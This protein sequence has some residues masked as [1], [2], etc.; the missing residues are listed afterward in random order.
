VARARLKPI[1][2]WAVLGLIACGWLW[3]YV[4]FGQDWLNANIYLVTGLALNMLMKG[5]FASE[6][7]QQ[8]AQDRQS[9]TLEL[10]LSTPLTVHD[11]LQGERLALQRQFLGPVLVVLATGLVLMI[12]TAR[13]AGV[14]EDRALWIL[15]WAGGMAM[16]VADL[17]GL[18]WVGMWQAMIS[19][20]PRTAASATVARLLVLPWIMFALIALVLA[21]SSIRTRHEPGDKFYFG[22]WLGLG[23]A[24]DIGFGAWAWHKLRTEF[25]LAA[26]QR[27]LKRGGF[28]KRSFAKDEGASA[29]PLR[30]ARTES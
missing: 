1:L 16:L 14:E 28:W 27:Y 12:A 10:L 7:G 4:K 26:A 9:G 30:S 17:A 3:G 15:V 6:V 19:K 22:I 18:Y 29:G 8:L 11:I 25:R 13:S 5:W 23:L 20:N 24:A 21:L 2:V